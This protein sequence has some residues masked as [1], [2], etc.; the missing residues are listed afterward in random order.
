MTTKLGHNLLLYGAETDGIA[1]N[2]TV[3][4]PVD[5]TNLKFIELKTNRTIKTKWQMQFYKKKLLKWWCQSF[6]VGI[7]E[8]ICGTRA[9]NGMVFEIDTIRVSDMPKIANVST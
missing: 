1:T 8:V 2:E 3:R 5:W 6:L 4:E 9:D 7:E